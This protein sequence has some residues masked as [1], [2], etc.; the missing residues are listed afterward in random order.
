MQLHLHPVLAEDAV[1]F[2]R[3]QMNAEFYA[4]GGAAG[5]FNGD[6]HGD[7]VVGPWIY[8]GPGFESKSRIYEGSAFEP[9]GYSKNFLMDSGDINHDGRTDIV[10]LGFPGEA[11]WWLENPGPDKCLEIWPRHVML[12]SVDNESPM[13]ID[14]DKDGNLDLICSSGGH[15]G[16]ASHAG[17][18]P[19]ALWR[20]H[21]I[22]PNNNYH[23][24]THGL[25]VGDVN[26]DGQ[27]DLMEKDGWWQNPGAPTEQPWQLRAFQFS[28]SGG[29]QMFAVDLDGD[30]RNEIVTSLQAH[31]FGLVYYKATN[32]QATQF[33]RFEIMT[34]QPATSPVGIAV[35]QLH[36]LAIADINGDSVPDIVTG[37]RWWAHGNSDPGHWQPATLLWLETN[38]LAGR[39]QMVA[40]V[41]DTSSGVG[42]DITTAD[43]NGDGLVD[44]VS[45]T[46]RGA[47]LF[48]Q[49]PKE[50]VVSDFLVPSQA[51]ADRFGQR[52][53]SEK[54]EKPNGFIP[55]I[56]GR[57]LNFSFDQVGLID[58]EAR[59]A[60]ATVAL[61][62]GLV[63]T[64]SSHPDLV[65]ELISR[66][67]LLHGSRLSVEMSGTKKEDVFVEVIS[68][69]TG[70]R[71]AVLYCG[72]ETS[73]TRREA[74]LSDWP[75]EFVRIRIVDHSKEGFVQCSRFLLH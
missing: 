2:E 34:D 67:F 10:I 48:L 64:G 30:G 61:K 65:G 5:D 52:P 33:D 26:M 24:F 20:F 32:D 3:I 15:Y 56:N 36:A 53:A 45:G 49:R 69:R 57:G 60:A 71:L 23:R 75:R 21:R 4:E 63:D 17:Q 37:K 58:W 27:L 40:H 55:A 74:D 42:T 59:G 13:M 41:V 46:K 72:N 16:Y 47:H 6:G 62:D 9:I 29:A 38:R 8:W 66:P 12:E 7:L 51:A 19:R 68:E 31:G 39:V 73:L 25:G 43:V 50:M 18:D 22:S 14:I 11:S 70:N 44:I 54:F 35:S 1:K 28:P